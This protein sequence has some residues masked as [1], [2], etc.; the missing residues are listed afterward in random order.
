MAPRFNRAETASAMGVNV[1]TLDRWVKEGC[2]V[3]QRGSRGIE[4]VFEL[5][6]VVRWYGNRRATEAQEDAPNDLMEIELRKER[7][8]M[9][10]AE[11]ELAK[12]KGD[13]A[14]LKEFEKVQAKAMAE[15][16]ARIMNVPQRVVMRLL[17]ESDESKF[18][19]LLADELRE[20]LE[21]ASAAD[22]EIDDEDDGQHV[23]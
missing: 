18:K 19:N 13:V 3:A 1:T 15:I 17:G 6:E 10:K 8:L 12:A 11:L 14:P 20:A 16:R 4:W 21:S 5:P 22:L 23:Q 9:L 7:A 2:P